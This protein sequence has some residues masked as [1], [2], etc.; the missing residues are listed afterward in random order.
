P[1]RRSSD[2]VALVGAS[3]QGE[4]FGTRVFRQLVNFGFRGPIYPVNPRAKELLGRTCYSSVSA[5]PETPDHV[6]IVVATERV[7]DV[8]E[9][10]AARGVPFATVYSGGFA[11]TGTPEG[12]ERQ[13]R[14]I[15]FVRRTGMRIMGP[16]CN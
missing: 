3:D 4:R 5:L 11:E 7:F 13:A 10:C 2:L 6:G 8:L 1:T 15:A 14:L 9:E 16:N 12:R